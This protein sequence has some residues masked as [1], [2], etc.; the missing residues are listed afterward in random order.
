MFFAPRH[1]PNNPFLWSLK[2]Q[3]APKTAVEK[4]PYLKLM[5]TVDELHTGFFLRVSG[6]TFGLPVRDSVL[7]VKYVLSMSFS[8]LSSSGKELNEKEKV[9]G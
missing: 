4:S 7:G 6:I 2:Q 8:F 9:S 5:R 3:A 1:R